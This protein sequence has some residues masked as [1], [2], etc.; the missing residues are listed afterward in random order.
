[1]VERI[2]VLIDTKGLPVIEAEGFVGTGCTEATKNIEAALSS[3]AGP[4]STVHKPE[5]HEVETDE[6][7]LTT[8]W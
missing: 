3:P 1:M 5:Y 8:S 7:H 6:Q 4:A 2:K